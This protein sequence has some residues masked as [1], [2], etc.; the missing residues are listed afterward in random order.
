MLPGMPS[1]GGISSVSGMPGIGT[2]GVM[3]GLGGMSGPGVLTSMGG[4][5]HM[6]CVGGM[7]GNA[8]GVCSLNNPSALPGIPSRMCDPSSADDKVEGKPVG[9][10][11]VMQAVRDL[12]AVIA[13]DPRGF[14][15]RCALPGVLASRLMGKDGSGTKEVQ[16]LTGTRITIPG[17]PDEAT[18][19]MNIEG[20]LL[21]AC[22]A[23]MLMMR[24]YVEAEQE[25]NA[26][27]GC[28]SG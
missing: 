12:P 13:Q 10:E 15:L 20:P 21:S 3:G 27:R 23:Y 28:M 6:P 11:I 5:S 26:M 18:R 2:M 24:R 8:M 14:L 4:A 9:A 7:S 25:I 17:N 22:A 16:D 19:M 1:I